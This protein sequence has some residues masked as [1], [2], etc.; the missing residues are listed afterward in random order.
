MA[1]LRPHLRSACLSDTGKRRLANEDATFSD[2]LMGLFAVADGIGGQPS[3]EA[4]SQIVVHS[5]SH[6]LRRQLRGLKQLTPQTLAGLMAEQ[7]VRLNEEI[8]QHGQGIATLTGM[9][10]TAVTLLLDMDHAVVTHAG[11]SRAY[12]LRD[13]RLRCLTEDHTSLV[14]RERVGRQRTD[15]DV[16]EPVGTGDRRLLTQYI[17]VASQIEPGVQVLKV[18]PRDRFMLCTDGLTDAVPDDRVLA[19]LR[20]LPDA[21]DACRAL[22]AAALDAGGRDNITVQIVDYHG[23]KRVDPAAYRASR[24]MTRPR[25][26]KGSA[27]QLYRGLRAI[28]A[29]LDWLLGCGREILAANEIDRHEVARTLLDPDP[30]P[31]AAPGGG[32][33]PLLRFHRA[34]TRAG[35]GW[36]TRYDGWLERIGPA[37]GELTAGHVRLSTLLTGDETA[38]I[39]RR[40]WQDW[41]RIEARYFASCAAGHAAVTDETLDIVVEHMLGSVRTLTGLM[42]FFPR[43]LRETDP[44]RP[45]E[46]ATGWL[47]QLSEMLE[48]GE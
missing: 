22:V 45:S 37:L 1:V 14:A 27:A 34:C 36:R 18:R 2:P 41:R 4:A 40:L 3:G 8:Y 9:G 29:E 5:I 39:L 21:T 7:L 48:R 47:D 19:R 38:A 20:S 42:E 31:A 17:G 23:A 35:G 44:A 28:E 6:L 30:L 32:D 12:L 46:Q 16:S 33:T 26:P 11:D 15:T 13:G 25:P 43:F 10:A 24:K